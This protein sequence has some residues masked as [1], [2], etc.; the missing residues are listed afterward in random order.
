VLA[1][2][3]YSLTRGEYARPNCTDGNEQVELLK[4]L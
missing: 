2:T 4:S 3:S 1:A